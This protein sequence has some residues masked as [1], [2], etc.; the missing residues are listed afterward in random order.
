MDV[1]EIE[2]FRAGCPFFIPQ[3]MRRIAI[4]VWIFDSREQ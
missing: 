4:F 1:K 2:F 3:A